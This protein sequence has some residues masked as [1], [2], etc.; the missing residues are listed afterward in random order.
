MTRTISEPRLPGRAV[1][2]RASRRRGRQDAQPSAKE[3][4]PKLIAVLKSNAPLK[5]KADACRELARIGTKDSVAPLAALLGDEKLAHMARYGSSRSPTRPLTMP[6]ATR[7]ASSRA[8][9]WSASSAAS[10][11]GA[12]PRPSSRWS[13]CSRTRM[14]TWPRPPRGHS[15]SFGTPAAAKALE[16]ALAGSPGRQ[17]TRVLR[18]PVPVCRS[19]VGARPDAT[20]PS[21]STI[22][23]NREPTAPPGP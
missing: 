9:R 15:G 18:G 22:G 4:E 10:E 11:C 5:D 12:T 3:Q 2:R 13:S 6:C 7:W 14:P 20:R 23:L 17:S 1:A 19:L 8:G 21:L 16:D